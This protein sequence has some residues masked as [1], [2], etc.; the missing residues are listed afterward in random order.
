MSQPSTHQQRQKGE[1]FFLLYSSWWPGRDLLR[2]PIHSRAWTQDPRKIGKKLANGE[3]SYQTQLS[4]MVS[5]LTGWERKVKYYIVPSF[6]NSGWR[7]KK[8]KKKI[9]NWIFEI[10]LTNLLS[11]THWLLIFSL[12]GTAFTFSFVLSILIIWVG[13]SQ[14]GGLKNTIR[15]C[16]VHVICSK[17]SA[18]CCQLSGELSESFFCLSLE[19]ALDL[20]REI[21]FAPSLRMPLVSK[22]LFNTSRNILL[23]IQAETWQDIWKDFLSI[24]VRSYLDT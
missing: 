3:N 8:K 16:G 11:G 22:G 5:M 10:W 15:Q 20:G 17:S 1:L 24:S 12:P 2:H 4:Q 14:F 21:F 13:N 9:K 19:M 6:P 7:A 23:F 18:D